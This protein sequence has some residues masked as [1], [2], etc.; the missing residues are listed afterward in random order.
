[1]MGLDDF[2]GGPGLLS[3]GAAWTATSLADSF[4]RRQ[5]PGAARTAALTAPPA[6]R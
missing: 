4:R 5:T 2:R 3:R 1:M 6:R